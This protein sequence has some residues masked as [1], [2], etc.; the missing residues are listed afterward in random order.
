MQLGAK[1]DGHLGLAG[2]EAQQLEAERV[3]EGD[4][5]REVHGVRLT[6]GRS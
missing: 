5:H 3:D 2:L 4:V 6:R 1:R